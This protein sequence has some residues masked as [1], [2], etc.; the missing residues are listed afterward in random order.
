MFCSLITD[1]I[2]AEVQCGE[3][4]NKIV[5]E[6]LNKKKSYA[7]CVTLFCCRALARCSAPCG[8]I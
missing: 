6:W 1:L 7:D 2:A 3:C 8:P 5:S 4:L